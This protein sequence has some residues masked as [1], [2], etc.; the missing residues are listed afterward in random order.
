MSS[1]NTHRTP[2]MADLPVLIAVDDEPVILQIFRAVLEDEPYR[3]FTAASG[4]AALA[5][6]EEHGCDL[7]LTD[8]NLPDTNGLE[9]ARAVR[10]RDPLAEVIVVTGYGSLDTAIRAMELEVFDY[11]LKPIGDVFDIRRKVRRAAE[12]QVMARQNRRLI[13][14]LQAKNDAL[15]RALDEARELRAELIQSEK[16]AGIGTLAAGVAHEVSSPLFGV[17]GLAEAIVDEDDTAVIHGHAREIISYAKAIRTIVQDLSG[18]ARSTDTDGAERVELA[19]CVQDALRLVERSGLTKGVAVGLAVPAGLVV[20][21]RPTELQQV[22]VNLIKNA[23][24]AVHDRHKGAGGRVEVEAEQREN[25][26]VLRVRDDGVGI[27]ADRLSYVFDP[28]YTTK[29]AGQGTGLGLN[30]VYRIITRHKGQIAVES[31][32]G[33]GTTLT[34]KLPAAG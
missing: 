33:Q 16:L 25:I 17:L 1:R 10:A 23:A 27:A 2:G 32:V 9:L 20:M 22:F 6:V 12:K 13:A 24:E 34:V 19:R 4:R 18:Y 31:V 15:Q 3:L 11:V 5:L 29:P 7:L 8:K 28:F 30:V 14:D 21:G 26:V